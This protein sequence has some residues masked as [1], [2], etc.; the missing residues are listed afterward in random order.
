MLKHSTERIWKLSTLLSA[1]LP[2]D[3]AR[4]SA[5][6]DMEKAWKESEA[7][8]FSRSF[9]WPKKSSPNSYSWKTCQQ[10]PFVGD[11]E[12]LEKLPK[13]GMIVDGAL[14]PLRR[15]EPLHKRERWF[16]LAYSTGKS[17]SRLSRGEEKDSPSLVCVL[18]QKN[19]TH[20]L[21]MN[22]LLLGVD[23][24]IRFRMDRTCALGNSVCS[25]NVEKRLKS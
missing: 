5:L 24:V 14:Y 21:K 6:Q 17:G 22:L 11:C 23:D 13:W 20:G 18:N 3:H 16:L 12:S 7:D 9:A 8:Y 2:N 1:G 4:T 15:S 10:L 25:S 19:G